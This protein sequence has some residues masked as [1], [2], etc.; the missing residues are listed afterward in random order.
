M[1][2]VFNSNSSLDSGCYDLQNGIIH[3]V[4]QSGTAVF[5]CKIGLQLEEEPVPVRVSKELITSR[6]SAS[7]SDDVDGDVDVDVDVDGD[8]DCDGDVDVDGCGEV[9]ITRQGVKVSSVDC[10]TFAHGFGLR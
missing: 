9:V 1:Q 2:R 7:S 10:E 3:S 6:Y 5:I 4:I 8:G